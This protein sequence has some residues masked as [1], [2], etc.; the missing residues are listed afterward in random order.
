MP[1]PI[2]FARTV[3]S[4]LHHEEK[5]VVGIDGAVV[6]VEEVLLYYWPARRSS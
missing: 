2:A 3:P 4:K 1:I 5:D 6:V